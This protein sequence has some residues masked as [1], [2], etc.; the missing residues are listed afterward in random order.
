MDVMSDSAF[1]PSRDPHRNV[2]LY[3]HAEMN[4]AWSP[5]LAAAP[6][7]VRRGAIRIGAREEKGDN[8]GCLLVYPRPESPL[9]MIAAVAGTGLHGMRLTDRQPYFMSGVGYP[10]WTVLDP[11]GVRGAGYFGND[12]A[13][14]SGEAAWR[15]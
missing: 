2:I 3:G 5:L 9:A 4:T 13:V 15:K 1:Q 8:L 12:W 14:E 11:A 6:V 10:D 7:Q